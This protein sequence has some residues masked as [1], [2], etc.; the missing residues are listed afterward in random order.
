MIGVPT[1]TLRSWE[2]RYGFVTP[3][4]SPGGQRVYSRDQV[5]QLRF[6][7]TRV[8]QGMQ[9]GDAH[10]LLASHAEAGRAVT[11]PPLRDRPIVLVAERDPYAASVAE[12]F[13]RTEGYEVSVALGSAETRG[14]FEQDVADVVV[15][16]L[17]I[18][19]GEGVAL[20]RWLKE[21]G[22]VPVLALSP[23][24]VEAGSAGGGRR[25]LPPEAGRSS[26]TGLGGAGAGGR[27]RLDPNRGGMS[28]PR[29]PSGVDRLDA[30]LG[31]G[32]V[33]HGLYV[34][35]GIPGTGK[36]MLAQQ[37][38][39]RNAT[40]ERPGVFVSTVSEPLEKILRY[41]DLLAYF[42]RSAIGSSVFY[43]D[44]AQ[45]LNQEGLNGFLDAID[46]LLRKHRPGILV[47]DSFK[48]LH[49]YADDGAGDFRVFLYGLASRLTAMPTTVILVGEYTADRIARDP[50]FAVADGIVVLGPV[51]SGGGSGGCCASPSCAGVTS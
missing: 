21:H 1:S 48:A 2:S 51:H 38:L 42:D 4:R 37:Y 13:L 44:L 8:A 36:T 10:R 43:H 18:S 9:P 35:V 31:G 45:V 6:V 32:L 26:A 49:A 28:A 14:T 15:V 7:A 20:T 23:A 24:L 29:I 34:L 46:E 47:I 39:F 25:C 11:P 12:Y 17:M 3:D 41:G 50:E 27:R 33:A 40:V 30:V 5:E 22:R 19:G 16:D